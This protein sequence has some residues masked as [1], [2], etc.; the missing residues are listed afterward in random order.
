MGATISRQV[1]KVFVTGGAGF[2]GS[3]VV[4]A[5]LQEG[6]EI[7][8]YDNLS[9]GK[10]ENIETKGYPQ[11]SIV[12]GDICDQAALDAAVKKFQPD[13]V[14]HLAAQVSVPESIAN[15]EFCR[16]VNIGGT[17]N[18]IESAVRY[19]VQKFGFASSAAV[20]GGQKPPLDESMA[21]YTSEYAAALPSPYAASKLIGEEAVLTSGLSAIAFRFFN[22][23][24]ARQNIAGGY[25]AVIPIFI[26]NASQYGFVEIYGDGNQT[27]DFIYAG[28][29]ARGIAS[30]MS[31]SATGAFNLGSENVITINDLTRLIREVSG[32]H[33]DIKYAAPRPG[34][35]RESYCSAQKARDAFGF[36]TKMNLRDGISSI[37][38]HYTGT[39][40]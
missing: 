19:G 22:V 28:D 38:Q 32:L 2:I 17:K 6:H 18:M 30:G 15:P 25:P 1:K 13:W 37:Y 33:F 23:Y 36:T 7:L 5:F 21:S 27:R 12:R 39:Q 16:K 40:T 26:K 35:I 34:D 9:S 29:I 14:V 4:G 24:G 11:V 10:E 31:G 20:Y 3:H 8:V